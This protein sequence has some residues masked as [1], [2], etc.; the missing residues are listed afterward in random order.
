MK[1]YT[2]L[3]ALNMLKQDHDLVFKIVPEKNPCTQTISSS[4]FKNVIVDCQGCQG[5]NGCCSLQFSDTWI[6]EPRP[7]SF[8]EA[9]KSKKK[10]RVEHPLLN[11]E[12]FVLDDML[13]KLCRTFLNKDIIDILTNGK[14]YIKEDEEETTSADKTK[15]IEINY[16]DLRDNERHT[17][18]FATREEYEKWHEENWNYVVING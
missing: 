3:E 7:V 13:D 8:M 15:F 5:Q 14:W 1:K 16:K 11:T 17:K 4:V 6:L 9:I 2:L 18:D 12:Y 10:I